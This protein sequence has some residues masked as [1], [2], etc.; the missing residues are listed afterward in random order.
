MCALQIAISGKFSTDHFD[1]G[2]AVSARLREIVKLADLQT[3]E[4]GLDS[5]VFF[6][7]IISNVFGVE[8]KSHRS[9]SRK[10]NAEFVNQEIDVDDWSSAD[11]H[12]RLLLMI[13]AL[14]TAIRLTRPSRL[15]SDAKD[16]IV[17][18]VRHAHETNG[19]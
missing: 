6:P 18:R 5:L 17:T 13:D 14:E 1:S 4:A 2:F 3:V 9:Y 7:V 15:G 8:K 11:E 19:S 12:S 16:T 10:E